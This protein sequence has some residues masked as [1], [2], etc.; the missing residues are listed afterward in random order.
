[1]K[2][3]YMIN[4]IIGTSETTSFLRESIP[5]IPEIPS[6]PREGITMT[7]EIPSFLHEGTPRQSPSLQ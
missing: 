2:E 5:M 1:M 4:C 7:L 6:F 3:Q